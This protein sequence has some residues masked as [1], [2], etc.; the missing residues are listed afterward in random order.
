MVWP[1]KAQVEEMHAGKNLDGLIAL[2]RQKKYL[3]ERL[4]TIRL[5][6]IVPIC[7]SRIRCSPRFEFLPQLLI[8]PTQLSLFTQS[9]HEGRRSC[10]AHT[11]RA[12]APA[13]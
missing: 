5:E 11:T 1:A 10:F 2:Y 13:Q 9:P 4:E 6:T 3:P 8:V 12:P 7:E